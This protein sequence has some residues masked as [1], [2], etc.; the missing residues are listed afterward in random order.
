MHTD[1]SGDAAGF[2][3]VAFPTALV[4]VPARGDVGDLDLMELDSLSIPQSRPETL[5]GVV[6][7][8]LIE[9]LRQEFKIKT[10]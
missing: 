3:G 1:V 8:R 7:R 2:L 10:R 9:E 6:G 4:L 5:N